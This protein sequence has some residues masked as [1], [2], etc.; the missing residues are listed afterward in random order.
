MGDHMSDIGLMTLTQSENYGTV[1]QAAAS[2]QL[3]QERLGS[4]DLLA[5]DVGHVRRRRVVSML[6][7]LNP[8]TGWTRARNFRSMRSFI[9]PQV[10]NRKVIDLG[11]RERARQAISARGYR[12]LVSGSD[13]IWNLANLGTD[14]LYV[15]P[16]EIA[17]SRYSLATSANRLDESRLSSADRDRIRSYLDGF[18]ML[19]VRDTYTREFIE[20]LGVAAPVHEILD[21][22]LL[23]SPDPT[24]SGPEHREPRQRP[25]ILLMLKNSDIAD[26]LIKRFGVDHE[27]VSVF[28]RHRGARLLSVT[29]QRFPHVFADADFVVTDFF[30]GTCMSVRSGVGFC[31]IDTERTYAGVESKIENLLSKL[32][33]VADRHLDLTGLPASPGALVTDHVAAMLERRAPGPADHLPRLHELRRQSLSLVDELCASIRQDPIRVRE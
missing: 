24:P 19:T 6:N 32:G 13:E 15:L 26:A 3:L 30:H 16:P 12:A 2:K 31:S 25:R 21:P 9:G 18:E 1:L 7:P 27:M 5:T 4:V 23:T 10:A 28:I 11:A 8:S 20:A 22:T 29:P 33:V 14:S 17:R